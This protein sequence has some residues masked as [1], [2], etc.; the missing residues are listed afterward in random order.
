V[1]N[2]VEACRDP[3]RI[4]LAALV[5]GDHTCLTVSENGPGVPADV[6]PRLFEP[7]FTTRP[8]GTGLGL[9][10]VRSV[11][12]AHGGRVHVHSTAAGALFSIAVPRADAEAECV[13][14]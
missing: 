7:F 3:G 11:A 1:A 12:E 4:E 13:D 10:V 5:V 14:E 6:R 9:A 8:Q 2:T